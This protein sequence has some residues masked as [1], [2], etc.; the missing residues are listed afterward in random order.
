MKN[1]IASLAAFLLAA[2]ASASLGFAAEETFKLDPVHSDVV[3]TIHHLVSNPFGVFHD[4]E[5]TVVVD[6]GV[7]KLDI[8]LP[9]D[10]ID[11][12]NKKWEDDIKAASWFDAKQFPKITFKTTSVK[13]LGE[14]KDTKEYQFEATGDLTLHGVTKSVTVTLVKTGEGKGMK[15]E[16]LIGY[17]CTF[18]I[19][20]S[21]FGMTT[22]KGPIGDEVTLMVNIEAAK[23]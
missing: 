14:D 12:G 9:V 15:G 6:G 19:N 22:Y 7:P 23:Q 3:F 2:G 11:M 13:K 16:T 1:R 8:S 18:K 21:D 4:P 10:K 5:G 17:S 20:R